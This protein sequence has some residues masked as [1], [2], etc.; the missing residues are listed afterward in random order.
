VRIAAVLLTLACVL[1]VSAPVRADEGAVERYVAEVLARSPALRA[2]GLERE[3]ARREASAAGIFPDPRFTVMADNL[4]EREGAQMPMI[5][6]QLE[7]MIPWPGKLGLMEAAAERQADVATALVD[8]RRAE[9]VLQAKRAFLMLALNRRGRDTNT[10][11]IELVGT[12][13]RASLARYGAG[14]GGHHEV[15][16]AEVERA[17][18]EA[19]RLDLE[20]ERTGTLAMVNALRDR[21][22]DTPI[23]EPGRT[24]ATA[25]A[26]LSV[27]RLTEKALSGRA[28]LRAMRAMQRESEAMADLSRRERYPDPMAGVWYNQMLGEPDTAGVMVGVALPIFGVARESRRASGFDA[29]AAAAGQDFA[30]MRAMIRFEV[31]DA[32]RKVDTA[33]R[34]LELL[35]DLAMP[36]VRDSFEASLAAYTAGRGDLAGLLDARRSLQA[37]DFALARAEVGREL[38]VAELERALGGKLPGGKR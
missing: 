27:E 26:A 9:L 16:R 25:V 6:Y 11:A 1:L 12:I 18:L 21:P 22:A 10:A 14:G 38:A 7:Q 15:A 34:Q 35:R 37:I 23:P 24:P 13:A 36:R 30:A 5:R 8:V 4:P 31:A 29:R 28:E 32:V 20:G 17:A 19:E 33:T 3:A 2:R